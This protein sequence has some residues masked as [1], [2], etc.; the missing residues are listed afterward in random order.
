LYRL[1]TL[2]LDDAYLDGL[3]AALIE[4]QQRATD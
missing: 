4:I 2:Y 1:L 3:K